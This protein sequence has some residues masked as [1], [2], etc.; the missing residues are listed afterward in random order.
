MREYLDNGIAKIADGAVAEGARLL[1]A[2]LA[3]RRTPGAAGSDVDEIAGRAGTELA[4]LGA[5]LSLEAGPEWIDEANNQRT[6]STLEVG[7]P[8]ALQPSVILTYNMGRGRSLVAGAPVAFS[9]EHGGGTLTAAVNTNALGQAT[10]SLG[11]FDSA[12]S[13]Q[14]VRA[15]VEF[16]VEGFAYR[17]EGVTKDFAYAPPGRSA[18]IVALERTPTGVVQPPV[19]LDAVFNAL[20]N[21]HLDFS[22]YD[23]ALAP[24]RFLKCFAG[25]PAS[26]KALGLEN[27]TVYL[28]MVLNECPLPVQIVVQ[29]K[30]M[31]MWKASAS[32]TVRLIRAADGKILFSAIAEASGQGNTSEKAA[33]DGLAR[34][35]PETLTMIK[36]RLA[37]INAALGEGK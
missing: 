23:G 31:N 1:V 35:V 25:D 22:H 4:K 16:R 13:E 29:G 11:R 30:A 20:K 7:T 6:G 32:A 12:A 18:V 14:V 5:A 34:A 33:H 10:C 37:E 27:N 3:E 19:I 8:R 17:F 36:S 15:A 28:V 24:D 9:F 26:I 2:V 21:V